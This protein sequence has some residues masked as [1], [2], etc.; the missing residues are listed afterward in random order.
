MDGVPLMVPYMAD[1]EVKICVYKY[2]Y[3]YNDL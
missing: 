3:I 1:V 2:I